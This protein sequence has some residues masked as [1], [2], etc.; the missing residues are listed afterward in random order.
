MLWM[1]DGMLNFVKVGI[2]SF[3]KFIIQPII[4]AEFDQNSLGGSMLG[5]PNID[6]AILSLPKVRISHLCPYQR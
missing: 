4:P 1:M 2:S 6:E 3:S 5:P